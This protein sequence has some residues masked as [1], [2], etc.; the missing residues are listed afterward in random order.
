MTQGQIT[1][2]GSKQNYRHDS[3]VADISKV[4]GLKK[5]L[6]QDF[7]SWSNFDNWHTNRRAAQFVFS[8]AMS[9]YKGNNIDVRCDCCEYVGLIPDDL[10]LKTKGFNCYGSKT[11]YMVHKVLDEIK[12]AKKARDN[13][14]TYAT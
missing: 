5:I 12:E 6:D 7:E 3:K 4:Q 11:A 10:Q 1:N 8:K 9:A 2:I 13:D 14:G